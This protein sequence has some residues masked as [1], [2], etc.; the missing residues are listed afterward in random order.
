VLSHWRH[1]QFTAFR[2]KLPDVGVI[3]FRGIVQNLLY[4]LLDSG[5]LAV[6]LTALIFMAIHVQYFRKPVMLYNI[7]VPALTFGWIYMA[8]S[9]IVAPFLVHLA[10]NLGMT[11]LFKYRIIRFRR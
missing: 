6:I 8:T 3:L 5:W 10:S 2:D 11:L 4:G 9:N 7:A 1:Q